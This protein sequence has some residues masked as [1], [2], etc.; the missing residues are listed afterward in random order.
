MCRDVINHVATLS[1]KGVIAWK[2]FPEILQF[3]IVA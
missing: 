1:H 3:A 2:N